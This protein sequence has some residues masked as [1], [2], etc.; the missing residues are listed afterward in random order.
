MGVMQSSPLSELIEILKK[1]ASTLREVGVLRFTCGDV[2]VELAKHAPAESDDD[3]DDGSG[4]DTQ[5][6]IADPLN[7]PATFGLEPGSEL[8]GFKLDHLRGDED[9]Q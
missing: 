7:D 5:E 6:F 8:P 3:D 9:D 1:D 4:D 2:S